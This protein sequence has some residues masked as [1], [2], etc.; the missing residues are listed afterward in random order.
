LST[1]KIFLTIPNP[2]SQF[3][4]PNSQQSPYIYPMILYFVKLVYDFF[5]ILFIGNM[6][7][8]P[9]WKMAADESGEPAIMAHTLRSIVKSDRYI[10]IPCLFFIVLLNYNVN[11][12]M[13]LPT[14]TI[15]LSYAVLYVALY[16][17]LIFIFIVH[18]L[19][20]TLMKLV[21]GKSKEEFDEKKYKKLSVMW[22][23]LGIMEL[24]PLILILLLSL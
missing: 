6:F 20:I 21:N 8:G 24:G 4:T 22:L 12:N 18:P 2:N 16:S 13:Y 17:A 19:R 14:S 1:A 9:F 11:G 10:T 5:V 15:R 23:L 7:I 3:P